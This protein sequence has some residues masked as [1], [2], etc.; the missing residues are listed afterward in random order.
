M[1]ENVTTSGSSYKMFPCNVQNLSASDIFQFLQSFPCIFHYITCNQ[2]FVIVMIY[3]FHELSIVPAERFNMQYKFLIMSKED[4][5]VTFEQ[6]F[7][8]NTKNLEEKLK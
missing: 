7:D 1:H 4:T 3:S 5:L 2:I 6:T 8:P